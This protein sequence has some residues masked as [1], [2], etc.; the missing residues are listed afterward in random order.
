MQIHLSPKLPTGIPMVQK[1][2]SL[3]QND[4]FS[5]VVKIKLYVVN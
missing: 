4:L 5:R 1:V 2:P 3:L